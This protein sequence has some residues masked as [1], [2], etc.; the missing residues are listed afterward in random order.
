MAWEAI[1][2]ECWLG[3]AL[4]SYK[5]QGYIHLLSSFLLTFDAVELE[6]PGSVLRLP[7]Q[8]LLAHL[9]GKGLLHVPGEVHH[10]LG[11]DAPE[12]PC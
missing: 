1:E 7:T 3:D 2:K 9:I 6:A 11:P 4:I 5:I 12:G 8:S 10:P